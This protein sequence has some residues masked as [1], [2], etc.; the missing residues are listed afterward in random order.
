MNEKTNRSLTFIK[1][2]ENQRKHSNNVEYWFEDE[3]LNKVMFSIATNNPLLELLD[4]HIDS[5]KVTVATKYYVR[6]KDLNE[7]FV[8]ENWSFL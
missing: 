2:I 3:Q 1:K 7:F 5:D 6:K 4:R 8:M